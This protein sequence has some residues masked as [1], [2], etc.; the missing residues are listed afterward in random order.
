MNKKYVDLT[1]NLREAYQE[2]LKAQT[3]NDGGTCNLDATFLILK[4]WREKEVLEA[5]KNA[6]LYCGGK[7]EWIGM[8]YMLNVSN[9][10]QGNDRT[11]IRD[12]FAEILKNKGYDVIHFDMMD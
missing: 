3:G 9:G 8:G 12:K 2:A 6:G 5:I 10:N 7:M 4:G 1:V 11:R